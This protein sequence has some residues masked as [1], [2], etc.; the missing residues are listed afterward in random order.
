VKIFV[1]RLHNVLAVPVG[2]VYAAGSDSYVFVRDSGEPR[3]TKVTIG[4]V[5]ETHAQVIAGLSQGQQVLILGAG[6]GRELLENAGIKVEAPA[7]TTQPFEG[8]PPIINA[9]P[10]ADGNAND[11]VKVRRTTPPE[12]SPAVPA[13]PDSSAA[14]VEKSSRKSSRGEGDKPSKADRPPKELRGGSPKMPKH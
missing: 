7:A 3:P 5:N 2:A 8:K 14:E 6:Q 4:Q 11:P 1:D 12:K 9:V 10:R 13:N